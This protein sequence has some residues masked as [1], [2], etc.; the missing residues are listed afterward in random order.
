M[1]VPWTTLAATANAGDTSITLTV[2]VTWKAGDLIVIATTGDKN[3]QGETETRTITSVSSD[4]LTLTLDEALSFTHLGV[5]ETYNQGDCSSDSVTLDIRAEVGLLSR[6]V[7]VLGSKDAQF[8]SVI[9]ACPAGF[10]TGMWC[11]CYHLV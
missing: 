6:N 2:P 8:S 7:R 1:P 11:C 10:D 9:A 3:S 5:S 4:Q